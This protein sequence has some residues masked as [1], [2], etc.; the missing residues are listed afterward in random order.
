MGP[1]GGLP[2]LDATAAAVH[3]P[4]C[5][6]SGARGNRLRAGVL[7]PPARRFDVAPAV[8]YTRTSRCGTAN[9][10]RAC[11]APDRVD[12]TLLLHLD[13]S[14]TGMCP[15][16]VGFEGRPEKGNEGKQE[17]CTPGRFIPENAD[18]AG[19]GNADKVKTQQSG[20]ADAFHGRATRTFTVRG[21]YGKGGCFLR[22]QQ[23]VFDFL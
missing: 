12:A 15:E 7:A 13:Q 3:D 17:F 10:L 22:T 8:T 5:G 14:V 16:A 18:L 1:G 21:L 4:R 6:G 9:A 19:H 2:S 20:N 23:R 11:S